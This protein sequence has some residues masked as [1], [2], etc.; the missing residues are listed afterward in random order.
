MAHMRRIHPAI[1]AIVAIALILPAAAPATLERSGRDRRHDAGDRAQ[2]SRDPVPGGEP[3][4]GL[5]GQG[6][7]RTQHPQL[8]PHGHDRRVDDHAGQAERDADQVLQHE[9]GRSLRSGHRDRARGAQTE[10]DVQ[11]DRAEPDG[12]T[13]TVLRQ[14]G[15]VRARK[16]AA[17]QEGRRGRPDRAPRGRPRWRWAS[18]TTRHGA[19]A[20][21]RAVAR[22]RARRPRRRRSAPLRSTTASTRPR[23]SH[24]AQR[25]SLLRRAAA[26]PPQL[27]I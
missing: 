7:L 6:G 18:A 13:G 9:R 5:S 4:D 11:A 20:G 17:D 23:A 12:Q 8:S 22:A 2:L 15:A 27:F 3:H 14:D 26:L 10:P 24:T 21:R 19:R 1:L 16:D 25:S